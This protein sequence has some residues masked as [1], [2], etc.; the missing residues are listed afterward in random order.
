MKIYIEVSKRVN[1]YA[2]GLCEIVFGHNIVPSR[3]N[4]GQQEIYIIYF[5]YNILKQ[6]YIVDYKILRKHMK[7][8]F[9]LF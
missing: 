3:I 6:I 1:F 5:V 4:G 8:V 2:F 7:K 9:R